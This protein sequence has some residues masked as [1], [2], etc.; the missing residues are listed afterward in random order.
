[1]N[2]FDTDTAL[3]TAGEGRF[4]GT[5]TDRWMIGGGPNGGY[6]AAFLMRAFT[7][8]S[9][10]PDAL[11][12]TTHY[13]G[14]PE[15]GPCEV[16]VE[17]TSATRSHAFLNASLVQDGS[18]RAH[19]I[20]VFGQRRTDQLTDI[21]RTSPAVGAPGDGAPRDT[22]AS[23]MFPMSFLDRFDYRDPTGQDM[24]AGTPDGPARV[25]GWTR[26]VD[27]ELD[28]LAV[29]LFAD[30]WPP[31]MF[32]RHGP[33]M[34]PTIELTVH[35]RHAPEP[36]WHWCSFES[37]ALAGG[38]VEEDGEVWSESGALVAQSRQLSRFS[39]FS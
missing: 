39:V 37:R 15:P 32:R 11:S 12:L 30:A 4:R 24:F 22:S 17:I 27:R 10:Q 33:G 29:P 1:M 8:V 23:P 26:L 18:V 6:I 25:G 28:Q 20:A 35:F 36:G 13:V 34:A 38:Y 2:E 19:A 3:D 16:T 7:A 21:R 9:P 31:P 14:R 5:V